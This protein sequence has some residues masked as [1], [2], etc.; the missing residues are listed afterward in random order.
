MARAFVCLCLTRRPPAFRRSPWRPAGREARGGAVP[1]VG[2]VRVPRA[3]GPA[4]S[5]LSLH[6]LANAAPAKTRE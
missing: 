3:G 2:S 5:T 1:G 6:A 4:S